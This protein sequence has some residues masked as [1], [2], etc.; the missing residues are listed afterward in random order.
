LAIIAGI[1]WLIIRR[2]RKADPIP[3]NDY[4]AGPGHGSEGVYHNDAQY[5][6]EVVK[7]G[8]PTEATHHVQYKT[9]PQELN[10]HRPYAELPVQYSHTDASPDS[11]TYTS[12]SPN[13]SATYEMDATHSR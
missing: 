13:Y 8:S 4:G 12:P 7:Y 1:A 2:G 11:A 6:P 9:E 5:A 10:A 3:N